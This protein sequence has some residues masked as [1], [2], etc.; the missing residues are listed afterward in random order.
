M[1]G[2]RTYQELN[3]IPTSIS[4]SEASSSY[5]PYESQHDGN[6]VQNIRYGSFAFRRS[7][8]NPQSNAYVRYLSLPTNQNNNNSSYEWG[9][10]PNLYIIEGTITGTLSPSAASGLADY[11]Q[12]TTV[13]FK[14]TLLRSKSDINENYWI[15]DFEV[16]NTFSQVGS[17]NPNQVL[18]DPVNCFV[19]YGAGDD[20]WQFY[21]HVTEELVVIKGTYLF[22]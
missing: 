18:V 11:E 19:G 5:V 17:F 1:G 8:E 3:F 9:V 4:G 16:I 13:Q 6:D 20:T 21:V 22:M 10:T 12:L 14:Q 2:S 7:T 15:H